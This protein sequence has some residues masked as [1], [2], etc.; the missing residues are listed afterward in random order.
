MQEKERNELEKL[1]EKYGHTDRNSVEFVHGMLTA[2]VCYKESKSAKE[3]INYLLYHD[4]KK[5]VDIKNKDEQ[6]RIFEILIALTRE[7]ETAIEKQEFI[8]L[9]KSQDWEKLKADEVKEWCKGFDYGLYFWG[10]GDESFLENQQLI[11]VM[12][13]ISVLSDPDQYFQMLR[14]QGTK[15]GEI[16]KVLKSALEKFPISVYPVY[17][18]WNPD[19]EPE[20]K[21]WDQSAPAE[22][23]QTGT[24]VNEQ[25]VGRNDP[26][27]CGSGKKYKKCCG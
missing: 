17:Y 8:P 5:E 10:N 12:L 14:K 7:I 6:I 15:D 22:P 16:I 4:I 18:F 11:T 27:P 9:I 13:P 1:L 26:C 3:Y 2:G 19:K 20:V 23:V 25:K 21:K 24:I